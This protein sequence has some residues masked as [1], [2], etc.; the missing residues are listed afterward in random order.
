MSFTL[1]HIT[2]TGK[3]SLLR[4]LR[5]NDLCDKNNHGMVKVFIK[6]SKA[7]AVKC[8]SHGVLACSGMCRN[9]AFALIQ[10]MGQNQHA[11]RIYM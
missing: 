8:E 3:T 10:E 5:Q 2:P 9:M 11:R 1:G 6:K 4:H 7:K